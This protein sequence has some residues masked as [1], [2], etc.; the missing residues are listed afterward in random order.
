[1]SLRENNLFFRL[2][3]IDEPVVETEHGFIVLS[4]E[5][6]QKN[7]KCNASIPQSAMRSSQ[8]VKVQNYFPAIF[9]S[10]W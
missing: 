4:Q 9:F 3:F 2:F 1:M 6:N 5:T 8:K 10:A 7:E